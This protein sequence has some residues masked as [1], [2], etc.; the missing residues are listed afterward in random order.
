M[1]QRDNYQDYIAWKGW[2][3]QADIASL[4]ETYAIEARR[5]GLI[6]GQR[7]L[8]FG[9]GQGNFLDW[10]K[11]QGYQ[12]SGVERQQALVD[13]AAQRGHDVACAK[14]LK[15]LPAQ[16]PLDAIV[17]LDVLEHMTYDELFDF[18]EQAAER[19]SVGGVLLIKVPNGVSPFGRAYQHVDVTHRSTLSHGR[20][21]Q[22]GQGYGFELSG[23]FNSARA[24]RGKRP[25]L[26]P[27]KWLLQL[28]R[29]LI[30]IT[31]GLLYFDQRTPLDPS[32][33]IVMRKTR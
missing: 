22:M 12:I 28:T 4:A 23:S 8:E 10:G 5:A 9:F 18:F 11:N 31:I 27:L 21:Q 14:S 19:L 6:S 7:I 33:T 24:M 16:Q 13:S 3:E 29:N 15:E 25:W 17:A 2:E 32:I 1:S 30:E 20:L 26:I